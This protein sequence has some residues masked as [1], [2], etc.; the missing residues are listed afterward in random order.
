MQRVK[1][2]LMVLAVLATA[3]T[4]RAASITVGDLNTGAPSSFP[5]DGSYAF[6]GGTRY[7]QVYDASFFGSSPVLIDS[8]TFYAASTTGETGNGDFTL[9][10]S[11][12]SAA[13]N[14]LS[15]N[16]VDN[17]GADNT[18]IFSARLPAFSPLLIF[19]LVQPFVYDP[20]QGNLLLDITLSGVTQFKHAPYVAHNGGFVGSSRMVNGN[21]AG[22]DGFGLVTTFGIVPEPATWAMLATALPGVL[23]FGWSRRRRAN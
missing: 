23:A 3:Q 15:A 10:L 18:V 22:T 14:G 1:V 12:T 17:L 7:Q 4:S 5:F 21:T 8:L 16:M 19:Q 20:T 11:T 9:S 13:V 2:V 6:L